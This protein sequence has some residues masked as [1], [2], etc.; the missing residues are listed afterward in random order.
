M[1]IEPRIRSNICTT[2]HPVG[3]VEQVRRQ[4]RY[5]RERAP[6]PG[7]KKVLVLGAS[8]GYGL[9]ARIVS[10]FASGAATVGVA[11]ERPG[12][13]DRVASAG[14]YN[15]EAFRAEADAAGLPAWN[16]NGDAFAEE[17]KKEVMDLV[18]RRLGRVEGLVYSIA[19]PRRIDPETGRIHAS[20]IKPLGGPFT[21]PTVDFMTGKV[22]TVSTE[23]ASEDEAAQTVKVMG[24]ED[25]EMWV[26]RLLDAGLAAPGFVTVAFSY[27]GPAFTRPIYRDGT[28][29]RAKRD[30]EVRAGR[31]DEALRPFG[32]RAWISV[33]K[34][35]VTRASAMIPALP[36]YIALLYR[37]M[38]S[39][40]LHEG[41]IEQMHRLYRDVLFAD[42]PPRLDRR[43]RIR[44]DD[45]EMREDVQREV[46]RLW[47]RVAS[48]DV[49]ELGDLEGMRDEFLRHHGF[50]MPGV[51]YSRDVD[52][53]YA[54]S[55][56]GA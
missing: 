40:G 44:M 1:I 46:R 53:S 17:T 42:S 12:A 55:G 9:A 5:V 6:V 29:G 37:V 43:G 11:Y 51:D 26:R 23:P 20:V 56:N 41:C 16:V 39:K 35:L 8:N 50:G 38:K 54:A 34:A 13:K 33:N 27:V 25:W 18:E 14:W 7:P 22:R 3:C 31:I 19:A 48:G 32:G 30:L 36:L 24:G 2:A 15:G 49:T 45:W 47:E 21:A 10:A 4:V 52:P 28:I